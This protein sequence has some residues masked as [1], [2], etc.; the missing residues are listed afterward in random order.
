MWS[1]QGLHDGGI[2]GGETLRRNG[3]VEGLQVFEVCP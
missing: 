3:L 2:G 1:K